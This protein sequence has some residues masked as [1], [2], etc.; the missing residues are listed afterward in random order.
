MSV[1]QARLCPVTYLSVRMTMS[2]YLSVS[3]RANMYGYLVSRLPVE[4][5]YVGLPICQSECLSVQLDYV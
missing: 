4:L 5:D 3:C 2:G 1:C